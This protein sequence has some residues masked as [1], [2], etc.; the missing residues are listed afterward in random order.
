MA[1][2]SWGSGTDF[3]EFFLFV[4][5]LHAYID[6]WEPRIGEVLLLQRESDNSE[7]KLPVA[8]LKSGRIVGRVLKT[9][10][11]FFRCFF[12]VVVIKLLSRLQER[13]SIVGLA[14]VWK[15]HAFI[16]YMDQMTSYSV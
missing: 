6:M 2:S 14:M 11:L 9:W 1:S 5:G 12:A 15:L 13:E 10:H 4:R 16:A 8:V 7:D 3:V